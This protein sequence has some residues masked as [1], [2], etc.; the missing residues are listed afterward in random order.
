VSFV[1][2]RPY[3]EL[4]TCLAEADVAVLTYRALPFV[5]YASSVKAFEYAA[6]GLPVIATATTDASFEIEEAGA[7]VL[8]DYDAPAFA[9]AAVDL[10]TDRARYDEYSERAWRCARDH[11]WDRVLSPLK[12]L[13]ILSEALERRESLDR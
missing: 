8:V 13:L 11:D 9:R 4:P 3:A 10:L 2:M 5:R 12:E 6:A 7:G 1:G